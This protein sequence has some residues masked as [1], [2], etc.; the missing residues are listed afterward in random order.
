M[1]LLMQSNNSNSTIEAPTINKVSFA[2]SI[3]AITIQT[4]PV[5]KSTPIPKTEDVI[6]LFIV[7]MLFIL[8]TMSP[9][10]WL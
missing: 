5:I 9:L 10:E 2:D 6:R 3:P 7:F 4:I 1:L 8:F